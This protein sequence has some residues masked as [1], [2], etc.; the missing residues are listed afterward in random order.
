IT[1]YFRPSLHSTDDIAWLPGDS[2]HETLEL[3]L[4]PSANND[5]MGKGIDITITAEMRQMTDMT[6]APNW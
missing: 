3:M 1:L 4:D 6:G 5:Y 2:H